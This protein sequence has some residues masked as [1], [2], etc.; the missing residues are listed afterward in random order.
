MV[1]SPPE[2]ADDNILD[3]RKTVVPEPMLYSL[4]SEIEDDALAA[5]RN[6]G[7]LTWLLEKAYADRITVATSVTAARVARP[8]AII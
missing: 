1:G 8:I 7:W 5:D 6:L 2:R 4:L 3:W